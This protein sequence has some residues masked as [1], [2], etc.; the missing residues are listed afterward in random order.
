LIGGSEDFGALLS[1][2]AS[3]LINYHRKHF[4]NDGNAAT[5]SRPDQ[6]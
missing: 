5:R 1:G 3:A 6:I 4:N 2:I